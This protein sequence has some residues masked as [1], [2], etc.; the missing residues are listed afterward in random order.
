VHVRRPLDL[1]GRADGSVIVAAGGRVWLLRPGTGAVQ[2]YASGYRS[3]GGEEPYITLAAPGHKGCS[4]GAGTVYALELPQPHAVLAIAST[5]PPRRFATLPGGGLPDGIAFDD[6]G[7]FGFRLLVTV[8]AASRTSVYAIDCRGKVAVITRDAPQVEGGI[9][10]APST[11]GRFAGDLIASDERSGRIFAIS[12]AGES[13]LVASSGLPHGGDVGVESEAF[14]P[15]RGQFDALLADRLTPGNRHP[16]DD[17]LL[18]IG[19]AALRVAGVRGGDLLA[20]TEGGAHTDVLTCGAS[21]CSV[22]H[23]ADGPAVSHPEGHIA[24]VPAR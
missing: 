7:H 19:A 5:G 14:V 22:R 20:A 21:A 15:A 12:P 24:M 1:A 18:R 2:P 3:R 11:F 10:V 8:T 13:S 9:A 17:V 23:L 6:T 16:G 4:F